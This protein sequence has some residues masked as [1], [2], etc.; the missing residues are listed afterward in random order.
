MLE[1]TFATTHSCGASEVLPPHTRPRRRRVCYH[2]LRAVVLIPLPFLRMH[3]RASLH[4][5]QPF[6]RVVSVTFPV[7]SSTS[8]QTLR[9]RALHPLRAVRAGGCGGYADQLRC[10]DFLRVGCACRVYCSVHSVAACVRGLL[11]GGR[12]D[13]D[14]AGIVGT[15]KCA[16]P[17]SSSSLTE[18]AT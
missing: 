2:L 16:P 14:P 18:R 9:E 7:T 10:G 5:Q 4:S 12:F 1:P 17:P 8:T 11:N 3:L 6:I 15:K 13:F